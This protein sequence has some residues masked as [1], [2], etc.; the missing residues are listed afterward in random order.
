MHGYIAVADDLQFHGQTVTVGATLTVD[1]SR[2]SYATITDIQFGSH[3]HEQRIWKTFHSA[4]EKDAYSFL[5]LYSTC[6]DE[7]PIYRRRVFEVELGGNAVIHSQRNDMWSCDTITVLRE[8]TWD[9]VKINK[10]NVEAVNS[11]RARNFD[12]PFTREAI[13][14]LLD[15]IART[16]VELFPWWG[17]VTPEH[18]GATLTEVIASYA[19]FTSE[20]AGTQVCDTIVDV[21]QNSPHLQG[22]PIDHI[23][24][25]LK[26]Y[27]G[28]QNLPLETRLQI[29]DEIRA[30]VADTGLFDEPGV[31]VHVSLLSMDDFLAYIPHTVDRPTSVE[32]YNRAIEFCRYLEVSTAQEVNALLEF[33]LEI[34][35]PQ[36]AFHCKLPEGTSEELLCRLLDS[37]EYQAARYDIE[38]ALANL[39]PY[40]EHNYHSEHAIRARIMHGDIS[41]MEDHLQT[42]DW[43]TQILLTRFGTEAIQRQL[44]RHKDSDVRASVAKHACA[45]IV[46]TLRTDRSAAVRAAVA[47]RGFDEDLDVLVHDRSPMVRHHVLDNVRTKD[48][49]YLRHDTVGTIQKRA[50]KAILQS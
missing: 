7:S 34:K 30:W 24:Y 33:W 17:T 14:D 44:M 50:E 13:C 47:H 2:L 29:R 46:H 12:G 48:I 21:F 23:E 43:S 45:D 32:A 20:W 35:T 28:N 41:T 6:I 1:K 27:L 15:D 26:S 38:K 39:N 8:M 42:D 10:T 18:M 22:R 4:C 37:T 5:Y 16:M 9:M 40:N 25:L 3:Q 49:N 31:H 19:L 36:D 11:H